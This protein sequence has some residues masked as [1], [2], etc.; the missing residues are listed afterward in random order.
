[1]SKLSTDRRLRILLYLPLI[2]HATLAPLA[3]AT[4]ARAVTQIFYAY[5]DLVSARQLKPS[6]PQL[7]R[8]V[9][10]GQLLILCHDAGELH[11]REAEILFQLLIDLLAQH[12][13]LW[14]IASQLI[15]GFCAAASSFGESHIG[16]Y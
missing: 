8:L 10:C 15:G 12:Q 7:H 1:M 4:I 5:S 6:W 11:R 2:S 3:Y 16:V 9:I 14:P 13:G